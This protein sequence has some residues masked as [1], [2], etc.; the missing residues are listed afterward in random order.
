MTVQRSK[1]LFLVPLFIAITSFSLLMLAIVNGW[2]GPPQGV[3]GGFCEASDGL[4]KQ[5]ANTWSNLGFI[6][7][8]LTIAWMMRHGAFYQNNN[9]F[10]QS[11]FTPVFFASLAV[12]LGPASM[13]M[14]ATL[15][16]IGGTL[17]MLSMYLVCSFMTAYSMQRFF[18]WKPIHFTVV[19]VSVVVICELA[20]TYHGHIPMVDYAGNAAFAF[21]IITASI[22][23][24]FNTYI[25]KYTLEK[26]WGYYSV[27]SVIT[28]FI[29][30][31]FGQNNNPFCDPHS[32][33]Q[34]HAM[35]HLLDALAV[36]F[37]FRFYVSEQRKVNT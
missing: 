25:R 6:A 7:A 15:T 2:M 4:I 1:L 36:F 23:E 14:H 13:A 16:P 24:I 18:G 12:L 22:F 32:L 33:I 21:F 26:K 37:L 9:A 28:A 19:F 35:W 27:A 3:G 34:G 8:G 5:P 31:N 30:W 10:T 20:G 17:D 11:N 29:I